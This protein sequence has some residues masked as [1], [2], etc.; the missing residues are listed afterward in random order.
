M[1]QK[2]EKDRGRVIRRDGGL[3]EPEVLSMDDIWKGKE[4]AKAGESK[5][6]VEKVVETPKKEVE[7][8]TKKEIVVE[9]GMPDL[10]VLGEGKAVAEL[11]KE[12]VEKAKE[13]AVSWKEFTDGAGEETGRINVELL[14]IAKK[15]SKEDEIS[16]I[17]REHR[18][19]LS[20]RKKQL[21]VQVGDNETAKIRMDFRVK[22]SEMGS[23]ARHIVAGTYIPTEDEVAKYVLW[24]YYPAGRMKKLTSEEAQKAREQ[25]ES[26]LITWKMQ[27]YRLVPDPADYEGKPNKAAMSEMRNLLN[28]FRK[29]QKEQEKQNAPKK[30]SVVAEKRKAMKADASEYTLLDVAQGTKV[31]EA[32]VIVSDIEAYE[33]K[34]GRKY[35]EDRFTVLIRHGKNG[36]IEIVPMDSVKRGVVFQRLNKAGYYLP[37]V[38]LWDLEYQ[39]SGSTNEATSD[40]KIVAAMCRA[41][42]LQEKLRRTPQE[43]IVKVAKKVVK[44]TTKKV[45]TAK[46]VEVKNFAGTSWSDLVDKNETPVGL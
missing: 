41:A 30:V 10:T 42:K 13:Q 3:K 8:E 22:M 17:V 18:E 2:R 12:D 25:R 33:T 28:A 38:I 36:A 35:E 39:V 6:V 20:Q 46:V 44:K 21:L 19:K 45:E 7:V 27:T 14:V 1:S 34:K 24:N 40:L 4:I 26:N 11:S 31:Q 15:F 5:E 9:A 16:P 32:T 37:G 43:K 29:H 23:L